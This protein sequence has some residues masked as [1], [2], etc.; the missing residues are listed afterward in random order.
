MSEQK[1]KEVLEEMF[2][3]KQKVEPE[4]ATAHLTVRFYKKESFIPFSELS[5]TV[6]VPKE[7]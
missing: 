2:R 1:L 3:E 5:L 6:K 4:C 7:E